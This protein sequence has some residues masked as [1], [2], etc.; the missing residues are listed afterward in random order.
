MTPSSFRIHFSK[1][2]VRFLYIIIAPMLMA[3]GCG[4]TETIRE[5]LVEGASPT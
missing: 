2:V 1:S 5:Q 4:T 3:P